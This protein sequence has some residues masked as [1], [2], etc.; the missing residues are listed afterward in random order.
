MDRAVK[1]WM[2][3]AGRGFKYSLEKIRDGFM[4][5]FVT[6]T[7]YETALREYQ[8]S[9][10]EVKSVERERETRERGRGTSNW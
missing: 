2:I 5:G 6:K 10:D 1:H 3:S 8:A 7:E 9:M 4:D